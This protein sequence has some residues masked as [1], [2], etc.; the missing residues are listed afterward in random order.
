M[1]QMFNGYCR[2]QDQARL[3]LCELDAGEAEIDCNYTGCTYRANC[4]IGRAITAWLRENGCI[5][6]VPAKK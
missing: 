5:D 3:V 4:Q 2:S 1:E 6:S